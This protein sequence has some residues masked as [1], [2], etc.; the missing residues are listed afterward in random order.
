VSKLDIKK[1]MEALLYNFWITKD[2]NQELYYKIKANQNRLKDFIIKNLG[3]NLIIHD[4]FIKLEK[5]PTLPKKN[6]GIETFTSNLDYVILM[7]ILIFLEDKARGD[8]FVLSD[9]VEYIKN[10]TVTLELDNIPDWNLISHR[11]S[12]SNAMKFLIDISAIKI[13]DEEKISFTESKDADALYESMGIS[14]YIMR[15]FDNEIYNI[16]EPKEFL[17]N[18]F[19]TQNEEKGDI[20]RYKVFRNILFTPSVFM[21]E[22]TPNEIDYIRKNRLYIKNE[23]ENNLELDTEITYNT[24]IVFDDVNSTEKDNFPNNKKITE[25]VLM[26][27]AKIL[28]DIDNNVL[29]YDDYEVITVNEGYLENIIREIKTDKKPYLSKYY[30]DLSNEKFY[31]EILE[32]MISYNFVNKV[33]DKIIIYPSVAKMIGITKEI[34]EN[35]QIDLFGGNYEEL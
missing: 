2:E 11:R 10:T 12:F 8:R 34:N 24:A 3:N 1:E 25:V 15:L 30:K 20:R 22:L 13:K 19:L 26:V 35:T 17:R 23:I 5:V 32:Y 4:R 9:L 28:E 27:N 14:N 18:E 33:N 6:T 16:T 7:I 29:T 21:A 31:E